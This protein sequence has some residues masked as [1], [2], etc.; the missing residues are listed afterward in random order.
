M[1]DLARIVALQRELNIRKAR[2]SFWAFCCML[3]P[4]FYKSDRWHLWLMCETLQALYG[5]R[6]TKSL[7][8]SLCHAP[9]VPAWYAGT[10]DWDRL[11]D[12][13][14]YTRLMQNLPPRHGTLS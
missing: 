7:F 6:L 3:A 4:D 11:Q 9:N 14:V 5:R 13:V 12:R 1:Q 8:Y 10:V 2:D